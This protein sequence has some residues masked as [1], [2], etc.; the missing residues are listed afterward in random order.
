MTVAAAPLLRSRPPATRSASASPET[1][2]RLVRWSFYLFVASIPFEYPGRSIPLEITTITGCIFLLATGLQLG[3]CFGRAP[4]PMWAFMVFLY[5]FWVAF[6]VGGAAYP[7]EALKSFATLLQLVLIFWA[8]YNLLRDERVAT[9]ALIVYALAAT[10]IAALTVVS[11]H[12]PDLAAA[13]ASGRVAMLEQ[14]ANR[15]GLVLAC[16][17]ITLVGLVYSR[18]RPVFKH[19]FL[20]WPL[21]VIIVAAELKGSS[22]GSLLAL[23]VGLW[24]FTISAPSLYT[25][26]RN[27]FAVFFAFVLLTSAVYYTPLLRSRFERAEEGNLAGRQ[28]IF[29][30]AAGMFLEKPF[31]GWGPNQNKYELAYRLPGQEW[32]R[33]DTHN[34][35]LEV[36]TSVGMLGAIPFALGTGLCIWGAW[37]ARRGVYG[38]LPFALTAAVMSAN[39]SSNYIAFKLHWL[40]LAYAAAAGSLVARRSTSLPRQPVRFAARRPS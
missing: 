23:T 35:I 38:T 15:A 12:N 31:F 9:E 39:M 29:P 3:R 32:D 13:R 40:V 1:V 19:R 10:A 34:L 17:A 25:K 36:V 8:A 27:S 22:R 7:D 18:P 6:A 20:V 26:I 37:R 2:H 14:N 11:S 30:T 5:G 16:G 33:R 24:T 28:I 4:S 21:L